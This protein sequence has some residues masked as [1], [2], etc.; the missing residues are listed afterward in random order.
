VEGEKSSD[1]IM[2]Q[3][4]FHSSFLLLLLLLLGQGFH[5]W[6]TMP[7]RSYGVRKKR[8]SCNLEPGDLISHTQQL[9][10]LFL[11]R[12][13]GKTSL[14]NGSQSEPFCSRSLPFPFPPSVSSSASVWLT[15][16]SGAKK[17]K[18]KK[19]HKLCTSRRRMHQE[20]ELEKKKKKK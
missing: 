16:K 17:K 9:A 11:L 15:Q 10:D 3:R 18:K 8:L 2:E 6:I 13:D 19:K 7:E 14:K 12:K 5:L 4:N 20:E 1:G